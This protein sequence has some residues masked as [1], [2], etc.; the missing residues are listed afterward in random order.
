MKNDGLSPTTLQSIKQVVQSN[1][2]I[3]D[4][5]SAADYTLCIYLLK[6]REYYRWEKNLPFEAKLAKNDVGEWLTERES[7]WESLE[8]S[9]YQSIEIDETVLNPFETEPINAA[10]LPQGLVY[11]GGIG[12]HHR[13]HFF[14]GKLYKQEKKDG[15]T[16][17]VSNEEYARDLTAPPAMTLQRTIFIRRESLR[18]MMWEKFEE[19]TWN[20]NEGAIS[21]ALQYYDFENDLNHALES[22]T[23][24][25]L[26]TVLL[27][28]LGE[29]EAGELLGKHFHEPIYTDTQWNDMLASLPRSRAEIMARAIRDNLAD[30]LST[31]PALL[32]QQDP[33]SLHF[34]FGNFKAMR[35]E[36]FPGLHDAY[37]QWVN[38][39]HIT[40]IESVVQQGARHWFDLAKRILELFQKHG[41]NSMLDIEALAINNKL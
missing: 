7:L 27:H 12:N 40:K 6:M 2:N 32:E 25:E 4:A 22:I 3:S 15:Y 23:D 37:Q 17:L 31:L 33:A 8:N 36:L 26:N 9:E 11:S 10:L 41:N 5:R 34:Y 21:K 24:H 35:K 39:E 1:C 29:I 30:C 28:E 38:N 13:P 16:I 18:R 20:K 14:L 19:W